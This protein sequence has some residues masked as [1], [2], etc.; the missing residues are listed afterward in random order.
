MDNWRNKMPNYYL[1]IDLG[2]TEVKIAVVN[3]RGQIIAETGIPGSNTFSPDALVR[4]IV[5]K[6]RSLKNFKLVSGVGAGVAGDIDQKN[7]IVRFSPNL[8]KWKNVRLKAM[9]RRYFKGPIVIDND[10]N[11]A[12]FGAYFLDAGRKAKNLICVTLGTGIGGGI[13]LDGKVY[14]G[15]TGTAGEIGH[16]HYDANGPLC[17]C[18]S[19][20]CIEVYA[21]APSIIRQGKKLKSKILK[22][23]TGGDLNNLT[24]KILQEAALMGDKQALKL[25]KDTGTKLGVIFADLVNTFNPEMIII[26]GGVS[27]ANRLLTDPIIS[28]V[29]KRAFK[30]AARACKIVVSKFTNRLGVVGAALLAE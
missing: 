29:S 23:L 15:A 19:H 20:G 24:P 6:S 16:I 1:G 10:A 14:R 30:T 8:T 13:I 4:K 26:S 12:A 28:T 21:G 27:K 18:G 5:E 22:R 9:L 17:N 3:K 11:A 25:W 2:G 7:G